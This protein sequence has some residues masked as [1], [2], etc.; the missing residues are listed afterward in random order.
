MVA[1]RPLR[2]VTEEAEAAPGEPAPLTGGEPGTGRMENAGIDRRTLLRWGAYMAGVLALPAVPFAERI[3]TAAETAPRLPVLWLNGQD[4]TGD[5]EGFLRSS[6][7][8][9]SELILDRLSLDYAELLMA[10]AGAAAEGVLAKALTDHAGRYVV[11]VEGSIPTAA[12]GMYCCI[13]GRTFVQ[14]LREAAAGAVAVIAVGSCASNGG[15]PAAAG[16]VTG[17]ASVGS[18]LTGTTT[19]IINL[20]GCPMNVANLTATLVQYATLGT[21]PDTDTAGLPLFAYGARIHSRCER[22][23]FFRAGQYVRTW[24]DAGHQAGWCLRYVGCQ[25]PQTSANCS[26]AK[27]NAATSWPVASGAPCLGCARSTFWS[28]L[29]DSF[30]WTPP[31]A[32]ATPAVAVDQPV[33]SGSVVSGRLE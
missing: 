23:P 15:L 12:S 21:W 17:A 29:S 31:V 30:A 7:P 13:G 10:P 5:L 33:L 25:G 3:A 20:P 4:C 11:V 22:L 16:G 28:K 8:T 32:A 18:V 27:F 6:Q 24:G 19:K 9:P 1:K 2:G 26:T 14:I